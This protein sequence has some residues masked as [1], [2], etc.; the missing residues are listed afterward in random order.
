MCFE[1]VCAGGGGAAAIALQYAQAILKVR[2]GRG[3]GGVKK[4]LSRREGREGGAA[5]AVPVVRTAVL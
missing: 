5:A 4:K 1:C 2:Q 3:V